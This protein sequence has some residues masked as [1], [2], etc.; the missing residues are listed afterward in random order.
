ME[1]IHVYKGTVFRGNNALKY[2]VPFKNYTPSTKGLKFQ[3]VEDWG[4]VVN[5]AKHITQGP[6]PLPSGGGE[7]RRG[8]QFKGIL[9]A[10]SKKVS[11]RAF[12]IY[13]E[14]AFTRDGRSVLSPLFVWKITFTLPGRVLTKYVY[15][16][17]SLDYISQN[18]RSLVGVVGAAGAGGIA[19][20]GVK[21]WNMVMGSN[22]SK[23]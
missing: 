7:G 9:P 18:P 13:I 6:L 22:G 17:G 21:L 2:C 1:E 12:S 19:I 15:M 10:K 20:G 5:L 4:E 8:F 14:Q 3:Y 23:K 11:E 16:L